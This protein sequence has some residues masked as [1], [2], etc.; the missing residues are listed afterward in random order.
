MVK[1]QPPVTPGQ[2]DGQVAAQPAPSKEPLRSTLSP[3][4]EP[5]EQ[6]P[7]DTAEASESF[8]GVTAPIGPVSEESKEDRFTPIQSDAVSSRSSDVARDTASLANEREK[9]PNHHDLAPLESV[10]L[11]PE[12]TSRSEKNVASGSKVETAAL[13]A[14]PQQTEVVSPPT[15]RTVNPPSTEAATSSN[16]VEE[17]LPIVETPLVAA[18]LKAAQPVVSLQ[19]DDPTTD[20]P[21]T[22]EIQQLSGGWAVRSEELHMLRPAESPDPGPRPHNK[23]SINELKPAGNESYEGSKWRDYT[24]DNVDFDYTVPSLVWGKR[25]ELEP[26]DSEPDWR[27]RA[28]QLSSGGQFGFGPSEVGAVPERQMSSQTASESEDS[29]VKRISETKEAAQ[30]SQSSENPLKGRGGRQRTARYSSTAKKKKSSGGG[31][32]RVR[33]YRAPMKETEDTE[34]LADGGVPGIARPAERRYPLPRRATVL[35]VLR[36]EK[37]SFS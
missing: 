15:Q 13:S 12:G 27:R 20:S 35:S 1:K 7:H 19:R 22:R 9:P 30:T 4:R 6:T 28:W 10:P 11:A 31:K 26:A 37:M 21:P 25:G 8:P 36:V 5:W 14:E 23:P 32:T 24:G 29:S 34:K 2:P 33:I 16:A 17:P 18:P 3:P